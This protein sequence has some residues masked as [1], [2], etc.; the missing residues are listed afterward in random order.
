MN[1]KRSYLERLLSDLSHDQLQSLL[2][3]LTEHDP[4]LTTV[5]EG[6]VA[7]FFFAR[8]FIDYRSGNCLCRRCCSDTI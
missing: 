1:E 4:S 2:L 6:Q 7:L 8:R 5:I 3:K